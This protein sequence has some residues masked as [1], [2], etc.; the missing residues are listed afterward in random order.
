VKSAEKGDDPLATGGIPRQFDRRLNRLRARIRQKHLPVIRAR[1]GGD[2]FFAE[3]DHRLVVEIGRCHMDEARRL[4]LNG[5]H[6]PRVRMPGGHDCNASVEIQVTVA[7]DIPHLAPDAAFHHEG[8]DPPHTRSV[9]PVITGDQRHRAR[10]GNACFNRDM[11][12]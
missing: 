1:H 6:N 10:S 8:V 9:D 3:R 11:R 4:I 12:I 2:Q 5:A 7:I